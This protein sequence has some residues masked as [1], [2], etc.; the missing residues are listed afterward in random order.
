MRILVIGGTWFLGTPG[1]GT[2]ASHCACS[3][4]EVPRCAG[5]AD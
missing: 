3:R 4:P 2:G 1:R 5:V